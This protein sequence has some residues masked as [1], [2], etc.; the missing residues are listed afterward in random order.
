MLDHY[1]PESSSLIIHSSDSWLRF[2]KHRKSNKNLDGTYLPR[3]LTAHLK[4]DTPYFE[5]NKF[6]EYYGHGGFCEHSQIGDRIVQYELELKEIEKQIIG[7]DKFQDNSSFKLS[8]NHQQFN[9]YVTLRK[10][11]DNYFNQ[12]HNYYEGYAYWLEKYFSLESG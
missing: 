3:T 11:F 8:K 10:E 12:H 9:Q 2:I 6:H 7:S 4:E 5:I 1:L